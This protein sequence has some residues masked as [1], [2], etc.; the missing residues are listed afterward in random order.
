MVNPA[1]LAPTAR[2]PARD[3]D[4]ARGGDDAMSA[5]ATSQGSSLTLRIARRIASTIPSTTAP[6][7]T[8]IAG[9]RVATRRRTATRTSRSYAAATRPSISS[10][11]RSPRPLAPCARPGAE[12]R[13]SRPSASPAPPPRLTPSWTAASA[14]ATTR[15]PAPSRATSSAPSSG[16]PDERSVPSVRIARPTS[17]LRSTSPRSEPE[18]PRVELEPAAS[19]R[20]HGLPDDRDRE[21]D[22]PRSPTSR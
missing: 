10:S 12:T 19:D 20:G 8:M 17:T 14:F 7:T 11:R 2:E 16:T 4:G 5:S 18:E 9:S 21:R 15:F 3:V 13:R 22:R 1:W 6:S